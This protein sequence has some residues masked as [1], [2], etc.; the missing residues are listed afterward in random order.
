MRLVDIVILSS[1][2]CVFSLQTA[3]AAEITVVDDSVFVKT[4][5]YEVQFT[6]GVI[7]Q[8]SNK[9]TEEVYTLPF[10]IS[11]VQTGISG[12]SGLLRRNG[13]FFWTNEATRTEVRKITPLKVE[14]AFSRG[15]NEIRLFITVDENT[16][17]LLIQQEG[18]SD[19]AGVYGIQWGCGNLNTQ[20]LKLILP[21][22]G[23]HVIDATSPTT[24]ASFDYPE[25]WEAQLAIVQAEHGGF[26]R[27]RHR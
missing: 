27:S 23:G 19:T 13:G 18:V 3:P 8:L 25:H 2:L 21:A 4:D 7:T 10:S 14:V 26:F 20:H 11:G 22:Q 24:S 16:G 15:A 12:R 9:L 17:D 1:V 6:E 5:T